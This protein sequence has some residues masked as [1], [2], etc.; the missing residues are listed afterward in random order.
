MT[1]FELK[2]WVKI[3]TQT[4]EIELQQGLWIQQQWLIEAGLDD[5]VQIVIQEGE[6]RI[7]SASQSSLTISTASSS[8]LSRMTH[9]AENSD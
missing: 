6:I 4:Q 2:D 3:M 7:I 9:V 5:K 1:F 8:P